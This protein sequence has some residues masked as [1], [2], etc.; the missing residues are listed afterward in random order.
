MPFLGEI[1][2]IWARTRIKESLG[3]KPLTYSDLPIEVQENI[4]S[5]DPMRIQKGIA[6]TLRKGHDIPA[7][8]RADIDEIIY[9]T[10]RC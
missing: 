4:E 10:K 6:Y 9:N 2:K 3:V 7:S 1:T 5:G 8:V